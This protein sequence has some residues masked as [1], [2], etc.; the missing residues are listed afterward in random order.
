[1]V[2]AYKDAHGGQF[3]VVIESTNDPENSGEAQ[4]IK[5]QFSQG[6]DRRARSRQEDQASFVNTALGGNFSLLLWRNHPGEDPD[7]QYVWWTRTSPINFGKFKDPQLQTLLDQGR[8]EPDPDEAHGHLRT[9]EQDLRDAGLQPLG[10]LG[11]WDIVAR[12][13]RCKVSW[14]RRSPTVAAPRSSCSAAPGAR[15]LDQRSRALALA[16]MVPG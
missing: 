5:E 7:A 15:S 2:T 14:G 11:Q 10:V 12:T 13:R 3:N 9:G 6:R 16:G 4:L 8:S 1:M